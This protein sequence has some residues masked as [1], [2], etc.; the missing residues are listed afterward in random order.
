MGFVELEKV[1][2][3]LHH[4]ETLNTNISRFNATQ[5]SIAES[6]KVIAEYCKTA[7]KDPLENLNRVKAE[8][9]ATQ[10]DELK[11]GENG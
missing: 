1:T 6:L 11:G 9:R 3:F 7:P 8:L 2:E 4:L 10:L 5:E